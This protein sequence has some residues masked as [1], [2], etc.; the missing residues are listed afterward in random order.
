MGSIQAFGAGDD[1]VAHV[2]GG[3]VWRDLDESRFSLIRSHKARRTAA[4][5]LTGSSGKAA[6]A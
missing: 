3:T 2:T 5:T 4:I 1:Q 6:L